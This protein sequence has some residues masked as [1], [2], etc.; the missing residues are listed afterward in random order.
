MPLISASAM[1]ELVSW[2]AGSRDSVL[3]NK[4]S[5]ASTSAVKTRNV[6]ST[7]LIIT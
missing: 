7:E 1:V 4:V 2:P 5:L 3:K 6:K